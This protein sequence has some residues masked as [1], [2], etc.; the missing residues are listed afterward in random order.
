MKTGYDIHGS[1]KNTHAKKLHSYMIYLAVKPVLIVEKLR[2]RLTTI[3]LCYDNA[4]PPYQ[5]SEVWHRDQSSAQTCDRAIT[6]AL[7][8]SGKAAPHLQC[9]RRGQAAQR[10]GTSHPGRQVELDL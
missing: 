8:R 4:R 6:A 10:G 3:K 9:V 2:G 7:P 1:H 5:V